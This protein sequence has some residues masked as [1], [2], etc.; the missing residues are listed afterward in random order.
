[1]KGI[2]LG[3]WLVLEKWMDPSVFAQTDAEDEYTLCARLPEDE[4]RRRYREHRERYVT[5][6]DFRAIAAM[7]IETVR[8]P[9]PHFLF[10]ARDRFVPCA[11]YLDRA[12]DWAER[13][14]LKLLID[15]HTVPGGHNGTDNSGICGVC[16]W[17]TRREYV[18]QT[19]EVL[20]TIARRYGDR[21]AM[22]GIEVLNEPMCADT[23][24]STM[25]NIQTLSRYYPAADRELAKDNENYSL[26]FLKD[27]YR[28]AYQRIRQFL[29]DDKK[30][31]FA[32]AF[33]LE[34]WEAFFAEKPF[35]NIVLDT[36]QYLT[37]VEGAF[38]E[39]RKIERYEEYF[40]QQRKTLADIAA[41]IPVIVGEWSLSSRVDMQGCS[42]EEDKRCILRRMGKGY[43]E[44]LSPTDGWFYWNYKI[45][46]Q[47]PEKEVWDFKKCVDRGWLI[48]E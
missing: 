39:N 11:E 5:E 29:P 6:A 4:K 30:V 21:T 45:M 43:L 18:D 3:N 23:P 20:E 15:L 35:T 16:T 26:A 48:L 44:M 28:E 12:F 42:S 19:L 7:G 46:D 47:E 27:F 40:A 14:G 36:H 33:Y 1:M 8:I 9:V 22:W 25:M 41:K 17:S 10:E 32:D 2:N 24:Y 38:G 34:G 37:I 31:V 13:T